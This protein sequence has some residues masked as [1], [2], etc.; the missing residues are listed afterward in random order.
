[1][2]VPPTAPP[3]IA[4][5]LPLM[6][7]SEFRD[8][9]AIPFPIAACMIPLL[10]LTLTAPFA[11]MP[12]PA[13][14][15]AVITPE[16]AVIVADA[17]LMPLVSP[18]ILPAF[19]NVIAAPLAS[20]ATPPPAT[21][22]MIPLRVLVIVFVLAFRW[23]PLPATPVFWMRPELVMLADAPTALIA[24]EALPSDLMVAPL[25]LFI[26][27]LLASMAKPTELAKVLAM[28]PELLTVPVSKVIPLPAVPVTVA[29]A[30]TL[31]VLPTS[32]K[33]P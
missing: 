9:I 10:L 32:V 33:V 28:V 24:L 3:A 7:T 25:R 31:M 4:L 5:E 29:P 11:R 6:V 21:E 12:T 23:M 13:A 15:W 17:A 22:V 19:D 8:W 16:L 14:A 18:T 27:A 20:I 26:M 1:M 30:F 2:A